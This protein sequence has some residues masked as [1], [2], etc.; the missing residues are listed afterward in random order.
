MIVCG[1]YDDKGCL[2]EEIFDDLV[3]LK[4]DDDFN[5]L[6]DYIEIYGDFILL[7]F[8]FDDLYE[9]YMEWLKF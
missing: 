1:W 7:M 6:F 4:Y 2:V 9:E 8:V 3:F 5:I